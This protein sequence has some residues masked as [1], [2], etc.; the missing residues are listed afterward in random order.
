[1][2]YQTGALREEQIRKL[3]DMQVLR[4]MRP[5]LWIG[6]AACALLTAFFDIRYPLIFIDIYICTFSI[7]FVLYKRRHYKL[8]KSETDFRPERVFLTVTE[9]G[10]LSESEGLSLYYPW[11]TYIR[12]DMVEGVFVLFLPNGMMHYWNLS[13]SLPEQREE[14]LIFARERVGKASAACIAP[15]APDCEEQAVA[16]ITDRAQAAEISDI[17][18][19][20][21]HQLNFQKYVVITLIYAAVLCFFALKRI[22]APAEDIWSIGCFIFGYLLLRYLVFLKHPGRVFMKQMEKAFPSRGKSS[23]ARFSDGRRERVIYPDGRWMRLDYADIQS[24]M[25]GRAVTVVRLAYAWLGYPNT[26]LPPAL[27]ASQNYRPQ[28][29]AFRTALIG[30]LLLLCGAGFLVYANPY[31]P[32]GYLLWLLGVI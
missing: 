6:L 5:G 22:E 2:V 3:A 16:E 24:S 26:A 21:I 12:A 14:L 10:I 23:T 7:T 1:M 19:T 15:P 17:V 27:P 18:V 9:A 29:W 11:S 28:A 20:S 13:T 25:R 8:W 31:Y 32:F 4:S 30:S